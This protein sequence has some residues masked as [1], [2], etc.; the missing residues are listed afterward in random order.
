MISEILGL[1][2]TNPWDTDNA[3]K[4]DN[5]HEPVYSM[6]RPLLTPYLA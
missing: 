1:L 3:D 6:R 2:N 5:Q 4:K